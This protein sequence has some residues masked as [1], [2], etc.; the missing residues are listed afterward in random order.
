VGSMLVILPFLVPCYNVPDDFRM[1][2]MFGSFYLQLFVGGLM[3][4]CS[5]LCM[6][7]YSDVQHLFYQMPLRSEFRVVMSAAISA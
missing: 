7:A 5:F 3:S 4:Y 2:T 1:K 6:F